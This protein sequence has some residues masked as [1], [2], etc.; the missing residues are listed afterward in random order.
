VF[1]RFTSADLDVIWQT[2]EFGQAS[3]A[4]AAGAIWPGALSGISTPTG[5]RPD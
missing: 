2:Q 4:E 3:V 1:V 5:I